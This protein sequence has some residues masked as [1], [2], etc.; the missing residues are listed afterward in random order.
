MRFY[1][2]AH[3]ITV[4][5]Q[6]FGPQNQVGGGFL[7]CASKP[8]SGRRQCEDTRRLPA[9]CFIIKQVGQGFP[10]FALKLAGG[11]RGIIIEVAWRRSQRWT[12]RCDRL[13]RTL[14]PN[15][16]VFIVLGHKGRLVIS[17]PVNRNPR[18]SGGDQ[19]FSHP[20]P[21]S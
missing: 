11:A 15:F 13:H 9:A 3:K 7:V 10:N 2:L 20:S 5:V 12:G 19:P 21:T 8:M 4:T 16:V 18:V 17:F 1:D 6:W 14:L